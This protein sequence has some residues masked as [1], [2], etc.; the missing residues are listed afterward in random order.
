MSGLGQVWLIAKREMASQARS[1]AFVISTGLIVVM[2][3]VGTL[4]LGLLAAD[5]AADEGPS[6]AAPDKGKVVLAGTFDRVPGG[7]VFLLGYELAEVP[8]AEA[9]EAAVRSGEAEAAIVGDDAAGPLGIVVLARETAPDDILAAL[10][11]TPQVVLLEPPKVQGVVTAIAG[12]V[13]ALL[14]FIIVVLYAQIAAQNTVVEKQTRV[15]ELLLSTM[16]ARAL[17]AGKILSNALLA[18]GTVALIA[19]ALVLGMWQ[20][21][22]GKLLVGGDVAQ[23]LGGATLWDALAGPMAWFLVFFALA[24]VMFAAL[25]VGSAA[26]VS[27]LEDVSAVIM[28][29]MFLI[30]IPYMLVMSLPENKALTAWLSFIPFSAPT[31]MPIRLIGGGV[32]WWQVAAS[33]ATLAVTTLIAILVGGRLYEGSILRTG[34]RVRFADA[35]RSGA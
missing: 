6:V 4:L 22:A 32:P 14:F 18:F 7:F 12:M 23:A 35:F 2:A 1:K 8:N 24:F 31:A 10:T 16:R 17:L 21:G 28:P 27:R 5:S 3:Y 20:G 13:F 11:F 26:T 34:A 25:M 9:A 29:T 30:M 33:L 19:L 15:I